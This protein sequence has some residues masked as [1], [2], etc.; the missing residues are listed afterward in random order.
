MQSDQ[1]HQL[2]AAANHQS[3]ATSH[4]SPNFEQEVETLLR[5]AIGEEKED[6]SP[7]LAA[8]CYAEAVSMLVDR[9]TE[10]GVNDGFFVKIA[11]FLREYLERARLL[12]DISIDE[13]K[14][15]AEAQQ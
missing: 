2:S 11:P 1:Y 9:A 10:I 13:E 4:S 15:M 12:A 7:L 5:T 14:A 3:F 8:Q 6:G